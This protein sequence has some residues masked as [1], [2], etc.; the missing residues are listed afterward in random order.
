MLG[1]ADAGV[2]LA[3]LATLGSAALC[4]VYGLIHWNDEDEPM[5]DPVHPPGEPDLEDEV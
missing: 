1:F 2:L 3:F 5:P 4:V